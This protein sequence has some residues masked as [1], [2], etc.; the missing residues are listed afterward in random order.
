[1]QACEIVQTML[2]LSGLRARAVEHYRVLPNPSLVLVA[3]FEKE[4]VPLQ[5]SKAAALIHHAG[6][7]NPSQDVDYT[8]H[9]T[10]DM[11]PLMGLGSLRQGSEGSTPMTLLR[12][13]ED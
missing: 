12:R 9:G 4:A 1:M 5:H 10:A 8:G 11:F 7:L 3:W 6:P 2:E 13:R